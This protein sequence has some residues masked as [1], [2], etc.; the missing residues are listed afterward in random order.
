MRSRL[1]AYL[2]SIAWFMSVAQGGA[3]GTA[4][5]AR[6]PSFMVVRWGRDTAHIIKQGYLAPPVFQRLF[7]DHY[8]ME[9]ERYHAG[10]SA[11]LRGLLVARDETRVV[12]VPIWVWEMANGS[13]GWL[14]Q[15]SEDGTPPSISVYATSEP[16]LVSGMAKAL[17]ANR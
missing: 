16:A 8:G 7:L 10:K 13:S 5:G 2:L 12:T 9:G 14:C 11:E 15:A 6:K 4:S 17:G 1:L 3:D